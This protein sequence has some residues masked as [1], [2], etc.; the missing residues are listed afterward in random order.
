LPQVFG[1]F[2]WNESRGPFVPTLLTAE[3]INSFIGIEEFKKV[4]R[5]K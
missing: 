4:P 5:R 1:I 2:P 3:E